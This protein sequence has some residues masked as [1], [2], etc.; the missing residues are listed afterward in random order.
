[1]R[2]SWREERELQIGAGSEVG[3]RRKNK[4]GKLPR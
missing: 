4:T 3:L 2:R 1:M